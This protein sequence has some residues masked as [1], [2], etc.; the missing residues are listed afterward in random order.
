[1]WTELHPRASW[2]SALDVVTEAHRGELATIAVFDPGR[3]PRIATT[4][5][6]FA[7]LTDDVRGPV[8]GLALFLTS[9]EGTFLTRFIKEPEA[10]LVGH[11]PSHDGVT[12][13]IRTREGPATLIELGDVGSSE[14]HEAAHTQD[15]RDERMSP[16][17]E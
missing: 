5:L 7:G 15:A 14:L 10:L 13:L 9:S 11:E 4:G 1:M 8:Q 12:L 3:K 17:V 2:S 16:V 6:P